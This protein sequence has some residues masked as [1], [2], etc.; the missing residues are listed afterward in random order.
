MR[1]LRALREPVVAFE[2]VVA[3]GA[4]QGIALRDANGVELRTLL[5]T[6]SIEVGTLDFEQ[7]ALRGRWCLDP[8]ANPVFLVPDSKAERLLMGTLRTALLE[9]QSEPKLQVHLG[10]LLNRHYRFLRSKRSP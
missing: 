1:R 10:A 2:P 5:F 3:L 7:E 9:L 8:G 6:P 4:G